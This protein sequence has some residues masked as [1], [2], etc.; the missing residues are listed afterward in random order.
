MEIL[1]L[2]H[3]GRVSSAR[4]LASAATTAAFAGPTAGSVSDMLAAAL[5]ELTAELPD[6]NEDSTAWAQRIIATALRARRPAW[7][8]AA[9]SVNALGLLA[10]G[11]RR[12]CVRE[13]AMAESELSTED[14]LSDPRDP[15]GKLHG[16]AIA[17][18]HL[19]SVW[20]QLRCYGEATHHFAWAHTI[21]SSRHGPLL[22]HQTLWDAYRLC[23]AYYCWALDAEA[24]GMVDES[25]AAAT[26][27]QELLDELSERLDFDSVRFWGLGLEVTGVGLASVLK[28]EYISECH[29]DRLTELQS[30]EVSQPSFLTGSLLVTQA[31]V[32]RLL[33]QAE[34]AVGAAESAEW[35]VGAADAFT[36][37]AAWR[38]AILADTS[39]QAPDPHIWSAQRDR[40]R[41][42][43]YA[44]LSA[45]DCS[46]FSTAA[47][48]PGSSLGSP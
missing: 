45:L 33:G 27:G 4:S 24:L 5:L 15:I 14:A 10:I 19:G 7:A 2:L 44:L 46:P 9:R 48:S 13:T 42:D 16:T 20:Q 11:D 37:D 6:F 38:E 22:S 1:R 25:I 39:R 26:R 17:H 3:T 35:L 12:T 8:A 23:T 47:R 30:G 29:L 21:A 34:V 43:I 36:V 41:A 28:P 32:A 40:E 18:G 31:R